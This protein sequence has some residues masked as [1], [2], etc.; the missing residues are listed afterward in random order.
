MIGTKVECIANVVVTTGRTKVRVFKAGES[1]DTST[2]MLQAGVRTLAKGDDG[3][4][5]TID[6]AK[7]GWCSQYFEPTGG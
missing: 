6:G 7:N 5:Y 2:M 1:Y 4:V 3:I